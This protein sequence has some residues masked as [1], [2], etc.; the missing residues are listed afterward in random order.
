MWTLAAVIVVMLLIQS[1]FG[2]FSSSWN[3]PVPSNAYGAWNTYEGMSELRSGGAAIKF[4][5]D[6]NAGG[7]CT[8]SSNKEQILFFTMNGCPHCERVKPKWIDYASKQ[9]NGG[10]ETHVFESS[11]APNACREYGITGFPSFIHA[12][13]NGNVISRKRPF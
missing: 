2:G 5:P 12:D 3:E 11:S 6:I 10:M 1:V 4:D 9:A 7:K 8:S 13:A